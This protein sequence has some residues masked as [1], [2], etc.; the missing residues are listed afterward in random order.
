[1]T[2][3]FAPWRIAIS[4]AIC[5]AMSTAGMPQEG[6]R[7]TVTGDLRIEKLDSSVFLGPHT[8][9]VWLPPGYS[10]PANAQ[11]RYPVLY[12]LDGQNMFDACTAMGHQEWQ[13]DETLTR[14]IGEGKVEPI[15]VVGVDSPGDDDRRIDEF[16]PIPDPSHNSGLEPR[17]KQFPKFLVSEVLPRIAGEYRVKTGRANT[18]IGGVSY[19]AIAALNALLTRADVFGIGLLESPS[20]QVGNGEFVRSTEHLVVPPLRVSIGVGGNEDAQYKDP[21]RQQGLDPELFNR[22]FA[23]SAKL[24]ADNFRDSGGDAIAVKFVEEPGATHS[25]AYWRERFPAAIEF[26][27]PAAKTTPGSAAQK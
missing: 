16:L 22:L 21:M 18:G 24:L 9:R 13:V 26:L 4:A 25:G 2:L 23:R 6:C 10:D 27:F 8:L 7:T 12:M 1:M 5:A 3:T 14:L 15:I 17:G 19:G 20:L 11:R